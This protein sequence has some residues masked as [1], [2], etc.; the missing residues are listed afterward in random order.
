MSRYEAVND[1]HAVG[2]MTRR[3][4]DIE[5]KGYKKGDM[6]WGNKIEVY[7][8]LFNPTVYSLFSV[9]G[10]DTLSN[11]LLLYIVCLPHN[12]KNKHMDLKTYLVQFKLSFLLEESFIVYFF[13]SA[14]G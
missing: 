6:I 5:V 13:Y 2:I 12:I 1:K 3:T 9:I 4:I 7:E 10:Q 14:L 11:C 8:L